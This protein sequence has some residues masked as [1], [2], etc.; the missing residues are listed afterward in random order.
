MGVSLYQEINVL[1]FLVI[2]PRTVLFFS[3]HAVKTELKNYCAGH[4]IGPMLLTFYTSS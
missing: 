2:R 3:Q 4:L 1:Y